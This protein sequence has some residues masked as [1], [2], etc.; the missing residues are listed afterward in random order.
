M[1][2]MTLREAKWRRCHWPHALMSAAYERRLTAHIAR[3]R[4][5]IDRVAVLMAAPN[6][7]LRDELVQRAMIALW[8][9]G[10]DWLDR[11]NDT[12]VWAVVR[13]EMRHQLKT[14]ASE[15]LRNGDRLLPSMRG[16][17]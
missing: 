13:Y 6:E 2:A 16:L 14:E 7:Q 8:V 17:S 11:Q 3:W 4:P 12:L 10:V 9:L 5:M 1:D 15:L